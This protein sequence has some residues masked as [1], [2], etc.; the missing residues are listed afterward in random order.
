[1]I[2]LDVLRDVAPKKS[3]SMITQ[4]LVDKLNTW[5]DDPKLLGGF[6]DNV[7]SYIGVLKTGRFKVDDYMN[8]VRFVSYKLIG[9]TDIDA[10]A[11]TFPERYQRLINSGETRDDIAPYVSSYKKNKLVVQIFEQTIVPSHVLNAP[12]HQEALNIAL[13]VAMTSGSDIAK[14]NACNT[15]LANTKPP[16][17]AKIDLGISINEGSII[18]DYETVMRNMVDK[19]LELIGAGGDLGMI[20]NASIKVTSKEEIIEA[21]LEETIFEEP[22]LDDLENLDLPTGDDKWT[23]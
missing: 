19:Q 3:R 22:K 17:T 15:I 16:E 18:D 14:V 7:L 11:I 13:H 9:H 6:K 8:A 10:Y 5:N 2:T 20:T 23:L 12:M 21:D 4:D 1:M